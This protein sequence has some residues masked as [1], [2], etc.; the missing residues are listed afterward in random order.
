[1]G[2]NHPC[3]LNPNPLKDR[4]KHEYPI[5]INASSRNNESP[6]L[7]V[8][9]GENSPDYTNT[10]EIKRRKKTMEKRKR[11]TLIVCRGLPWGCHSTPDPPG[12]EAPRFQASTGTEVPC[13]SSHPH[14]LRVERGEDGPPPQLTRKHFAWSVANPCPPVLVPGSRPPRETVWPGHQE[15]PESI[16]AKEE[17]F[18]QDKGSKS[19]L[20]TDDNGLGRA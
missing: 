11:K 15:A 13:P 12:M 9:I 20:S 6:F 3:D 17:L 14:G 19:V 18:S 8:K 7:T 10:Q 5:F 1:M 4:A 2:P 16:E